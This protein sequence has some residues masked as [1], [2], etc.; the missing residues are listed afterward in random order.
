MGRPAGSP[1]AV[2]AIEAQSFPQ[3]P[4]FESCPFTAC[5]PPSLPY[6]PVHLTPSESI[7]NPELLKKI[8]KCK[9]LLQ[10]HE[11]GSRLDEVHTS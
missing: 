3:R 10:G 4:G 2:C 6:L 11:D 8:K 1:A 7:T 9:E 5:S